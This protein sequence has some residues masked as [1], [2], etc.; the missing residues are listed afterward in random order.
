MRSVLV[1]VLT[2]VAPRCV[3]SLSLSRCT[4][5]Y[6]AVHRVI[7]G[8]YSCCFL[9]C[10]L[11]QVVV[12]PYPVCDTTWDGRSSGCSLVLVLMGEFRLFLSS[13]PFSR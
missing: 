8:R 3:R 5:H 1:V 2:F 7:F 12:L 11:R 6:V 9:Y 4:V 13:P 10:N